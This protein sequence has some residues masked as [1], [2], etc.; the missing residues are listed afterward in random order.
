M[1]PF[2]CVVCEDLIRA[3][4]WPAGITGGT[5]RASHAFSQLCASAASALEAAPAMERAKD[6][7]AFSAHH[8]VLHIPLTS[9]VKILMKEPCFYT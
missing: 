4:V 3:V 5:S 8:N 1:L 7:S 6:F 9:A 2:V